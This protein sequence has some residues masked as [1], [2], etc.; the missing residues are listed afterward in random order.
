MTEAEK[1]NAAFTYLTSVGTEVG[2]GDVYKKDGDL[3]IILQDEIAYCLTLVLEQAQIES[4]NE[5]AFDYYASD[6]SVMK[7]ADGYELRGLCVNWET[8][9]EREFSIHFKK[10]HTQFEVYRADEYFCEKPWD[11]LSEVAVSVCERAKLPYFTPN[12]KEIK[13]LP[14]LEEISNFN[15][16]K[17]VNAEAKRSVTFPLLKEKAKE[18]GFTKL[19]RKIEAAEKKLT[20]KVRF[21]EFYKIQSVLNELNKVK[22]EKLWREIFFS[23]KA[24]Q[25]EYPSRKNFDSVSD[26]VKTA[27]EI[28]TQKLRSCGYS[29]TYPDFVKH[30]SLRGIHLAFS[31]NQSYFIGAEKN[32]VYYI[33]CE[34]QM[35]ENICFTLRCGTALLKK[36]E[37][38]EDI[39]SCLFNGAGRR[40]YYGLDCFDISYD[41]IMQDYSE[42]YLE[43]RVNI[44]VKR[45]EYKRLTKEERQLIGRSFKGSLSVFFSFFI[46]AGAFFGFFMTLGFMLIELLACLFFGA[47]RVF[48]EIFMDT[49]WWLVFVGAGGLFGLCMGI[50][51]VIQSRR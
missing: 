24:S 38:A 10:A 27:R 45:T 22:Y 33:H 37:T 2:T 28:I 19:I 30:G 39:Y 32:V 34:E 47:I 23:V 17:C 21:R 7:T 6:F 25:K 49:P 48:P 12:E 41:G 31:Y 14:L 9:E 46:I 35:M 51:E 16:G 44:A 40:L 29:G 18:Y 1:T 36:N 50:I 5:D 11:L 26:E 20:K 15:P 4:E 43:N 42:P 8:D 13:L 3:Y